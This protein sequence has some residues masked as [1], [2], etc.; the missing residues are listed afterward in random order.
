MAALPTAALAR[1]AG[2]AALLGVV[3]VSS[4][5]TGDPTP[6]GGGGLLAVNNTDPVARAQG[7]GEA[8]VG[9]PFTLDG[10]RS[11]DPDGDEL[12]Y[13]WSVS[14]RPEGS[15]LTENPFTANGDR[16]AGKTTVTIDVAGVY[17]FALQVEDDS[18]A[19]SEYDFVTVDARSTVQLP[20]ADAG[21]SRTGLEGESI[22]LDGSGSFDP[23]GNALTYDWQLV[24]APA[25]SE[26]NTADLSL[27][28]AEA[29]LTP[30]SAGNYS[31]ALV[32]NN[33]LA[34]SEPDFAFI[35]AGS[36]NQG[37]AAVPEVL[38]GASCSFVQLTGVNSTDPE[39]DGL[40]FSW[41]LVSSPAASAVVQGTGAF[42][43]ATAESPR[44]YADVA[45]SYAVSLGVY[46][47]EAWSIPQLLEFELEP[48][49]ANTPPVARSTGDAYFSESGPVCSFDTYG[50]CSCSGSCP[51]LVVEL[52]A[53][54]STDPDGDPLH[55][56]WD[57]IQGPSG[58]S[59]DE[60]V[61]MTNSV[62]IPGPAGSC[63]QPVT[64]RTVQVRATVYDCSGDSSESMTTI[65]Y[66]CSS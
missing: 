34:D 60:P 2:V 17:A 39:G 48:T 45:G 4:Q 32:V 64:T 16:N 43:D 8:S 36:T 35:L 40:E 9:S 19:R 57:V 10:T 22:C 12:R 52:D 6:G 27:V 26:L 13:H 23:L 25:N 29:C 53:S 3:A 62:T 28:D 18:G 24:S 1:A 15:E 58:V 66:D 63:T 59:L 33:G 55:V 7:E 54:D 30:D 50:N 31:V 49:E 37:P 56:E 5:C 65:V 44:F 61:G 20:L 14:S 46:D 11:Y 47:G 42:D 38:D 41:F 51:S 21:P